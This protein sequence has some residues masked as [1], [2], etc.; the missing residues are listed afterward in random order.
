VS[1]LVLYGSLIV[2]IRLS[3]YLRIK[4]P[5]YRIRLIR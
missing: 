4:L 2:T 1:I 5:N 3:G